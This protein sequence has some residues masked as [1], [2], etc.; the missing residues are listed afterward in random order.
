METCS[1]AGQSGEFD[2]KAAAVGEFF[3]G[4]GHSSQEVQRSRFGRTQRR[5]AGLSRQSTGLDFSPDG[6]RLLVSAAGSETGEALIWNPA[7][8]EAAPRAFISPE[9]VWAVAFSPDGGRYAASTGYGTVRVWGS[10]QPDGP[11]RTFSHPWRVV[12]LAFDRDGNRLVTASTDRVVRVWDA[13]TGEIITESPE[14]NGAVWAVAVSPDGRLIASAGRDRCVRVWDAE[15]GASVGA[16][17]HHRAVVWAVT[18]SPDGQEIWSGSEDGPVRG[19]EG[20]TVR[21]SRTP[22]TML[23][24]PDMSVETWAEVLTGACLDGDRVRVLAPAEWLE[25]RDRLN[26][27]GVAR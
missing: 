14:H 13:A 17:I 21:S 23:D 4:F 12:A 20:G 19:G 26:A 27:A 24:V 16:P 5:L 25:R 8:P 3:A 1:G 7:A 9:P 6:T 18:F 15:T 22:D 11:S 2:R 10:D